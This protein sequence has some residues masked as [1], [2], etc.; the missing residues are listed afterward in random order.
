MKFSENEEQSFW[1]VYDQYLKAMTQ[2]DEANVGIVTKYYSSILNNNFSGGEAVILLKKY[3]S[4][5]EERLKIKKSFIPKFQ[6]VIEDKNVARF[7]QLD[8]K[9]EKLINFDFARKIPLVPFR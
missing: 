9:V 3:F 4:L 8:N 5:E 2:L 6:K 7:F 1:P